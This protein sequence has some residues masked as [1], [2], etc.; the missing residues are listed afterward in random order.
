MAQDLDTNEGGWRNKKKLPTH[1]YHAAGDPGSHG[2]VDRLYARAKDFGILVSRGEVQD[3][4]T[5][6]LPYSIH[7]PVRHTFVR[8]HTYASNIEQQ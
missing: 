2:G 3:Y 1:L 6:R 4:L 5:K 7:K 8:N